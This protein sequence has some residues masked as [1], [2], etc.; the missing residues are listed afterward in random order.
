MR[1]RLA[2]DLFDRRPV[3]LAQAVKP[4]L[5][6]HEEEGDVIHAA[7]H[8]QPMLDQPVQLEERH[9]FIGKG[10]PVSDAVRQQLIAFG[11]R[12]LHGHHV[13]PPHQ[14]IR[15]R[16]RDAD[17]GALQLL[18][19]RDGAFGGEQIARPVTE[20]A[21]H[22]DARMFA[23][24]GQHLRPDIP[25]RDRVRFGTG[26]QERQLG[27]L[28]QGEAAGGI[29]VGGKA[30]I[31]GPAGDQIEMRRRRPQGRIKD[32]NR[33]PAFRRFL[34]LFGPGHHDVL[35]H[36]MRGRQPVRQPQGDLLC[37]GPRREGQC[38]QGR[39]NKFPRQSHVI[40]PIA[41]LLRFLGEACHSPIFQ[42]R[43][44]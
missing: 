10:D 2:R 3:C 25:Q 27:N 13:Q 14:L 42:A 22:L 29:A 41:H 31:G 34:H 37:I 44:I 39:Q 11:R 23:L 26:R 7:R 19:R 21:Q 6:H 28:G 38:Q 30:Q 15:H 5:I 33:D 12:R 17:L 40:P 20:Q 9:R 36:R 24:I 1:Q 8:P 18:Q 35:D 4:R 16:A 32:L 43:K